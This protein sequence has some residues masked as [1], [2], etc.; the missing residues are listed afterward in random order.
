MDISSHLENIAPHPQ[1]LLGTFRKTIHK[2]K[3]KDKKIYEKNVKYWCYYLYRSKDSMIP[4]C[5]IFEKGNTIEEQN[6]QYVQMFFK[7]L[8]FCL[9]LGIF[10]SDVSI[11]QTPPKP[12][13]QPMSVL[14]CPPSL[15]CQPMSAFSNILLFSIALKLHHMVAGEKPN[16]FIKFNKSHGSTQATCLQ[17]VLH[18]ILLFESISFL[19]RSFFL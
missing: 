19:F 15:L 4:V 10:V 16:T 11:I 18:H 9:L 1:L 12:L 8:Y 7:N 17:I 13:C 14:A 2:K 5:R 6:Y 3:K